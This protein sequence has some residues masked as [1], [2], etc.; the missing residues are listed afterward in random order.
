ME[1]LITG[2][3]SSEAVPD[4]LIYRIENKADMPVPTQDVHAAGM[5]RPRR[6]QAAGA[7]IILVVPRA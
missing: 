1:L 6:I 7:E 3:M 2:F 4:P 5:E